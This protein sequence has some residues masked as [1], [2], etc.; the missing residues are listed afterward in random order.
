MNAILKFE[1]KNC[2]D[3]IELDITTNGKSLPPMRDVR[4]QAQKKGWHIGRDCYCPACYQALP[5]HCDTC[6][7]Y[8]GNK[9]MGAP[10]CRRD[11]EFAAPTDYCEHHQRFHGYK[12]PVPML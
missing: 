6:E 2:I 10:I 11:G 9:S 7:H 8:E 12:N 1:C 3:D 5:A 4:E